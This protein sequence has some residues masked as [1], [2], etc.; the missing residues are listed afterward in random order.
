METFKKILKWSTKLFSLIILGLVFYII[1]AHVVEADFSNLPILTTKETQ[2]AISMG[3]LFLG[4]L[5]ALKWELVGGII[6]ILGYVGFVIVE[7][8]MVNN[9]V[10]NLFLLSGVLN[11]VLYWMNRQRI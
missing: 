10:F 5:I 4:T 11:L 7:G 6:T 9:M 3:L 1:G 2:L 8:E